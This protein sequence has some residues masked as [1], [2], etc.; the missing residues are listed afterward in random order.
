MAELTRVIMGENEELRMRLFRDGIPLGNGYARQSILR[1][2]VFSIRFQTSCEKKVVKLDRDAGT[3]PESFAVDVDESLKGTG[4][5]F[6]VTDHRCGL[7]SGIFGQKLEGYFL[8]EG[9]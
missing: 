9:N 2:N 5:Y 8:G 4:L 7:F 6:F 3:T 1:P